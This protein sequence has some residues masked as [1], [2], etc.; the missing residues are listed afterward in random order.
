MSLETWK[1]EFYPVGAG[2]A[3]L[4]FDKDTP[5]GKLAL[6][7]HAIKKWEGL[8]PE[9]LQEHGL[10]SG[11]K[12]VWDTT[13]S[14]VELQIDASTCSLCT[15][16]GS[17]RDRCARCPLKDCSQEFSSWTGSAR[18]GDGNPEPMLALLNR[19]RKEIRDDLDHEAETEERDP[20]ETTQGVPPPALLRHRTRRVGD[21]VWM[22]N[23]VHAKLKGSYTKE[24]G[25]PWVQLDCGDGLT[26]NTTA[27]RIFLE[28]PSKWPTVEVNG[29]TINA[30][31]KETDGR[32]RYYMVS[33]S[34]RGHGISSMDIDLPSLME[35][36][37]IYRTEDDA[38]AA[39][40][41]MTLP[42]REYVKGGQA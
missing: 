13:G 9:A 40:D 41:A 37:L 5:H 33:V 28:P 20:P 23:G 19:V 10:A 36:G 7:D 12:A 6:I 30:P 25:T 29:V 32:E 21:T 3:A 11:P 2:E 31:M 24:D 42:L 27:D 15:A 1:Q 22:K 17:P 34:T 4:V 26:T 35:R 16:Y 38:K 39:H 14:G 8:R 18:L